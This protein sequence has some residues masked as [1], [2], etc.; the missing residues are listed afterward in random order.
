VTKTAM[1]I[2]ALLK[3]REIGRKHA[4]QP[5]ESVGQVIRRAADAGDEDAKFLIA[6]GFLDLT[7]IDII[8]E[9]SQ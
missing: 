9:R 5:H 1:T 6:S 4:A 7:E 8:P 3:V 2:E